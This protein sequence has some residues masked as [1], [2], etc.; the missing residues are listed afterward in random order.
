[1]EFEKQ[2]CPL[3]WDCLWIRVL[4]YHKDLCDN[5]VPRQRLFCLLKIVI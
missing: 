5:Q 4:K 1:M 2:K 3:Q